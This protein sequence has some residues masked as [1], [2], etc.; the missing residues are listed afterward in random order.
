MNALRIL[1]AAFV[2]TLA[3]CGSGGVDHNPGPLTH[4][5]GGSQGGPH[6]PGAPSAGGS[7]LA[8][9]P[10]APIQMPGGT[11]ETPICGT[12]GMVVAR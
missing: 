7:G 2:L 5:M 10:C 1:P 8:V 9:D 3:A 4:G 12:G 6:N 11:V